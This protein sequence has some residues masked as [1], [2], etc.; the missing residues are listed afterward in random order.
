M[1]KNNPFLPFFVYGTLIPGQE[2]DYFWQNTII[3]QQE[4]LF[5]HGTLYNFNRFPMLI[6]DPNSAAPVRG[7]LVEIEPQR[8][9]EIL[10]RIDNL[11]AYN[12][13][14]EHR[15]FYL[16]RQRSVETP[17]GSTRLAWV[18]LGRPGQVTGLSPVPNGDWRSFNGKN[19]FTSWWQEN[20]FNLIS[21]K[22]PYSDS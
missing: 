7:V 11:E 19:P 17:C 21:G 15:S 12:P 14:N 10:P 9:Q 3:H 5:P 18:Y 22:N 8:Y 2:N 4:A 20:G 13:I 16:R 1:A 6:E